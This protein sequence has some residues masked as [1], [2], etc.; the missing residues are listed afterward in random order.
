MANTL[1]LRW[2]PRP[3]GARGANAV[4][5]PPA[6]AQQHSWA[7]RGDGE[8]YWSRHALCPAGPSSRASQG[9]CRHALCGRAERRWHG[10]RR[11]P[12]AALTSAASS[13]VHSASRH[14][15]TCSL[16]G[17]SAPRRC[18]AT[19]TVRSRRSVSRSVCAASVRSP[20]ASREPTACRRRLPRVVSAGR[21]VRDRPDVCSAG[22]HAPAKQHVW[23]RQRARRRLASLAS[24]NEPRRNR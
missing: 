19:R 2:S 9:S 17:S 12:L 8:R 4:V 10:S 15:G 22:L 21:A 23:R 1:V 16:G 3:F 6:T 14:T 5:P 11:R 18:C 13:A 20:R 24:S 7:A